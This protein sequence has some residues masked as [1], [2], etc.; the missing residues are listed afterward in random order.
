MATGPA[1][2]RSI[3]AAGYRLFYPV[4]PGIGNASAIKT[5]DFNSVLQGWTPA[6]VDLYLRIKLGDMYGSAV[7]VFPV[8]DAPFYCSEAAIET[9]RQFMRS[10]TEEQPTRII[11]PVVRS[12]AAWMIYVFIRSIPTGGYILKWR[13][14]ISFRVYHY[15]Q[16]NC[17]TPQIRTLLENLLSSA[18]QPSEL[19]LQLSGTQL[20][21]AAPQLSGTQLS[22]SAPQLLGTQLSESAPQLS[23]TQLSP[24]QQ[25]VDK[26]SSHVASVVNCV[27]E[28]HV[29]DVSVMAAKLM[30]YYSTADEH[31]RAETG[32]SEQLEDVRKDF[33]RVLKGL[34]KSWK[35]L[36]LQH[37]VGSVG[38]TRCKLEFFYRGNYTAFEPSPFAEEDDVLDLLEKAQL[39]QC[40]YSDAHDKF[41]A[42]LGTQPLVSQCP[43]PCR[44]SMNAYTP[45]FNRYNN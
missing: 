39:V 37:Y 28:E 7:L 27:C 23:G 31:S 14:A 3:L 21:E 19:A 11:V 35:K 38:E 34:H 13:I 26:R 29:N 2:V 20:S 24:S 12:N 32:A 18:P 30:Q 9:C 41:L 40:Q 1:T 33:A 43:F 16:W 44:K 36:M 6:L 45:D 25:G 8:K 22:E 4:R 10:C 42:A 5:I 17:I 15:R